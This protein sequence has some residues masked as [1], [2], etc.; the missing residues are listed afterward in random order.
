NGSVR[1]DRR[2][3]CARAEGRYVW[4][5]HTP[6]RGTKPR[7]RDGFPQSSRQAPASGAGERGT[8]QEGRGGGPSRGAGPAPGER[9]PQGERAGGGDAAPLAAAPPHG[10]GA[11]RARG[12]RGFPPEAARARARAPREPQAR[13]GGPQ[14]H[15]GPAGAGGEVRDRG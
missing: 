15:G 13:G 6:E 5:P 7:D 4:P 8:G 3:P 10:G 1:D 12:R 14:A 11:P 2:R 9:A